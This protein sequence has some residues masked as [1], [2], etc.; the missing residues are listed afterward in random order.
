[1]SST[2]S[3]K[4]TI[5]VK[6]DLK[7]NKDNVSQ[8]D[9]YTTVQINVTGDCYIMEGAFAG[10][11]DLV[12]V[13]IAGKNVVVCKN[14]FRGCYNLGIVNIVPGRA[15]H[16]DEHSLGDCPSLKH[17][18][19]SSLRATAVMNEGAFCPKVNDVVFSFNGKE[20]RIQNSNRVY[21]QSTVNNSLALRGIFNTKGKLFP[22]NDRKIYNISV[23]KTSKGNMLALSPRQ[24]VECVAE[25]LDY[26]E[27]NTGREEL[28]YKFS[29]TL[30]NKIKLKAAE[31][32][33]DDLEAVISYR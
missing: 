16:M 21:R 15:V 33:S 13:D 19:I 7:I 26:V 31:N 5:N 10:M 9:G 23:K 18:K 14:A 3:K 8:F 17:L 28:D 22:A 6:G 20:V 30:G 25:G 24:L 1:M 32:A 11:Q 12:E 27:R 29:P 4:L 2:K